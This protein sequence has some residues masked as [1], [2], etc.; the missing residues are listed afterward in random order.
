MVCV[1]CSNEVDRGLVKEE[2]ADLFNQVDCYGVESLT[3][4][5]QVVY[6]GLCCSGDCYEELE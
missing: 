5:E 4:Y 1:V 6:E 3:E 2:F